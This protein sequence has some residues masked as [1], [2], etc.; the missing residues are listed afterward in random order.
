[1]SAPPIPASRAEIATARSAMFRR[2]FEYVKRNQR[3]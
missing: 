2:L 1:M 3:E